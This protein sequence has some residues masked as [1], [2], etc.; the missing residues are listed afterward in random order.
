MTRKHDQQFDFYPAWDERMRFVR[1]KLHSI[2]PR[3]AAPWQNRWTQIVEFC[4]ALT[5]YADHRGVC[6]ASADKLAQ[7]AKLS[8]HQTYRARKAAVELGVVTTATAFAGGVRTSDSIALAMDRL[9]EL[10]GWRERARTRANT[11][12]HARTRA[13]TYKESSDPS[14]P[15]SS[16]SSAL[17]ATTSTTVLPSAPAP[18]WPEAEG[19]VFWFGVRAANVAVASVR[20]HGGTPADVRALVAYAAGRPA[21]WESPAGALFQRLLRWRRGQAVAEHWPPPNLAWVDPEKLAEARRLG[22]RRQ[23]AAERERERRS[24]RD[25]AELAEIEA[26]H[27]AAVDA[28]DPAERRRLLPPLLRSR[29]EN[30]AYAEA[31]RRELLRR[32]AQRAEAAP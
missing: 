23:A 2:D 28:L 10:A 25:E 9:E 22:Q 6:R 13:K 30:P 31:I 15:K 5:S 24:R 11:R 4:M 17:A 20:D 7:T 19:E 14:N 29:E 26:A 18:H 32:L 8:V 21:A 12:E 27:G 16:S 1:A 3:A